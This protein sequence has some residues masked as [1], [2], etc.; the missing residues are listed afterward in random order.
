[1]SHRLARHTALS[2]LVLPIFTEFIL[3]RLCELEDSDARGKRVL[4][5]VCDGKRLLGFAEASIEE[6]MSAA[7]QGSPLQ[8]KPAP[9]PRD[10]L[11]L[12]LGLRIDTQALPRGTQLTISCAAGRRGP[13][14]HFIEICRA[15]WTR[16]AKMQRFIGYG[17]NSWWQGDVGV[18]RFE[19]L[20]ADSD[21]PGELDFGIP[22]YS[23]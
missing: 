14:G 8:L 7:L 4:F 13:N 16:N 18:G 10:V 15:E 12:V 20:T 23:I 21:G 22:L 19:R 9:A 6:I 1:M 17:E 5:D 3:C 11:R 2:T